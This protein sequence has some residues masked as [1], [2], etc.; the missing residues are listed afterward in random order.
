MD[1]DKA[2]PETLSLLL[3]LFDHL[4][5]T[6]INH[7]GTFQNAASWETQNLYEY[8]FIKKSFQRL[9]IA[10]Q[11]IG[12]NIQIVREESDRHSICVVCFDQISKNY[13]TVAECRSI[14]GRIEEILSK[15]NCFDYTT[16]VPKIVD[17]T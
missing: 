1:M 16:L 7:S 5:L 9:E 15:P 2:N 14:V 10:L 17:G 3:S 4:T 8:N 12:K 11:Q 6:Q 13:L